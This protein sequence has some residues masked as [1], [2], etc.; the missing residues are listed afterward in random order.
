MLKSKT[1]WL[2]I[3]ISLALL[4][5]VF[6]G[7]DFR[8]IG[9]VF[10]TANYFFLIPALILYFI[11][12]AM[13]AIRWH[14]LLRSIK[15]IPV[16]RLFQ[17]TVI[18]YMANDLLPFRI[19]ELVRAYILGE[20]EQIS[21]ASTLVTIVLER[22]FDGVTMLL[23]IGTASFFLPLDQGIRTLLLVGSVLFAAVVIVLIAFARFRER[24]DVILDHI[25][26]RL[27]EPWGARSVKLID[28]FFHGLSVLRNPAD[29]LAALCFSILAWL[30][31]AGMY[32][33]LALGFNI[34]VPFP[35]FILATAVANLVTIV[36]STP[37]YIGVFDAPV[38][39][40]LALFGVDHNVAASFT[41]LLHATLIVPVVLLGLIFTWRLGLS[42]GQLQKRSQTSVSLENA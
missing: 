4:A 21:K 23:F 38:K 42:L 22:V 6:Y 40:I 26:V 19:G 28:S 14:F 37:G 15:P 16:T 12:V 36:P 9:D 18:G 41:L 25:F 13:R 1:L 31:E 5:F 8:T 10:R 39:S 7:T 34:T 33:V 35:V 11:G 30:F 27:P 17:V 3:I 2:G 32:A 24:F 29:A 20:T